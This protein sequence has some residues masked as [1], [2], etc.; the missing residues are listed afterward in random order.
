VGLII[1][2]GSLI[3]CVPVALLNRWATEGGNPWVS[4]CD[5]LSLLFTK[6]DVLT[7]YFFYTINNF[8]F[9]LS[10]LALT[11]RGSALLAFLSL[12]LVVP[13]TAVC[14]SIQWPFIGTE[15]VNEYQWLVLVIMLSALGGFRYGNIL[16]ERVIS[17]GQK[18]GCCYPLLEKASI[19]G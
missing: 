11:G 4:L 15:T 8:F 9:N 17:N 6:D 12:K 18:H 1:S 10:L 13:L 2:V 7:T 3:T 5:G 16:R 19:S 14:S